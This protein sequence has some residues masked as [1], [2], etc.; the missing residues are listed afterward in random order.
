[1]QTDI[2]LHLLAVLGADHPLHEAGPHVK[3]LPM[4]NDAFM[5]RTVN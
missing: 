1:M 4:P 3:T 2:N 5:V